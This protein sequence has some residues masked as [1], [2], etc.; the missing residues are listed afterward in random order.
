M[1]GRRR[2][3]KQNDDQDCIPDEY[4]LIAARVSKKVGGKKVSGEELDRLI[5]HD[6]KSRPNSSFE[7]DG[8]RSLEQKKALP[9]IDVRAQHEDWQ[10]DDG[11]DDAGLESNVS[12]PS[13]NHTEEGQVF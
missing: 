5:Q 7:K 9:D 11:P 12:Q 3:A 10:G 4:E 1:C 6:V 2:K 8:R 13:M